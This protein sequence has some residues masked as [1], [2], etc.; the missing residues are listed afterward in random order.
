M[1]GSNRGKNQG[2]H[3]GQQR[4]LFRESESVQ[5]DIE[6]L[7]QLRSDLRRCHGHN[8]NGNTQRMQQGNVRG[9]RGHDDDDDEKEKEDDENDGT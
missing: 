2:K 5:K 9:G 8:D 3:H 1:T 7:H 6:H 4:D